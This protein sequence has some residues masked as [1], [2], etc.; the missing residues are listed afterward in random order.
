MEINHLTDAMRDRLS[1]LV[2]VPPTSITDDT[3]FEALDVDSLMLLELVAMLE[4]R[5]GYEL[6]EDALRSLRTIADV[7][8]YL[9]QAESQGAAA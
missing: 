8:A 7:R 2:D 6:P 9:Q 4:Q 1:I 3:P 5:L